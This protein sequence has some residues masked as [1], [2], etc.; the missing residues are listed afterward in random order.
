MNALE[1]LIIEVN[2][3]LNIEKQ[4]HKGWEDDSYNYILNF[5]TT[6]PKDD[7]LKKADIKKVLKLLNDKS[8]DLPIAYNN[9]LIFLERKVDKQNKTYVVKCKV[10]PKVYEVV[11]KNRKEASIRFGKQKDIPMWFVK[12]YFKIRRQK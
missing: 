4:G 5:I 1:N 8:V 7:S 11:A 9:I 6:L 2:A 12:K 10:T 3:E